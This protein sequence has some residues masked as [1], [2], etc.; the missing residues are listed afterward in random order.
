MNNDFGRKYQN[1]KEIIERLTK[2]LHASQ[3]IH[4]NNHTKMINLT[5]CLTM[6][7]ENNRNQENISKGIKEIV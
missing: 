7:K 6:A 5:K 2:S 1:Y 3:K 4:Q